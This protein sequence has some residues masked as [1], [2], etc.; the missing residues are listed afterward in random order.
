[1]SGNNGHAE[2]VQ[3]ILLRHEDGLLRYARRLTADDGLARDVVQETFLRLCQQDR[4]KL[5]GHLV[6]WLYT[7]CRHRAIDVRRKEQRMNLVAEDSLSEIASAQPPPDASLETADTTGQVLEWLARLP[8]R[9]QEV[10]RL[11][12]QS[13]LQYRE[14]ARVTG[15]TESYVG[16]LLHEA[17][18]TLRQKMRPT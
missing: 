1:M 18:Q 10:V 5:D 6:E 8:E 15:L 11:K 17:L 2:W 9:Q 7:V 4:S 12:F 13:G 16:V 3:T 14:I